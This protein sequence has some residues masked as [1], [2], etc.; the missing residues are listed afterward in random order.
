MND[1]DA[2]A[3]AQA[4]RDALLRE[5]QQ[6]LIQVSMQPNCL[7]LLTGVRDQMLMFSQY[8]ANRSQRRLPPQFVRDKPN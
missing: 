1:K 8:K 2:I 6:L 4:N 5:C 7:K 3:S